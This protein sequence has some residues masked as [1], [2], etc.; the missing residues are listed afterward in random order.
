MKIL[1]CLLLL[2]L[3]PLLF[4]GGLLLRVWNFI[5][6]NSYNGSNRR[7]ENQRRDYGYNHD[8]GASAM[9]NNGGK[10]RIFKE[11]EGEYVD[12]EEIEN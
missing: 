11:N 8:D 3:V 1:G 2:I 5:K 6:G 9:G 10:K 4:A 12:F 7:R